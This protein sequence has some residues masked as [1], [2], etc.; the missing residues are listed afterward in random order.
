MRCRLGEMCARRCHR[1]LCT[2]NECRASIPP[3]GPKP[4][5]T[6]IERCARYGGCD[7]AKG[8]VLTEDPGE[9][10]DAGHHGDGGG[11]RVPQPVDR[12]R[13]AGVAQRL[14]RLKY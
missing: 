10:E 9:S 2:V 4:R 7:G 11:V 8:P 3:S 13:S 12:K 1:L 14:S 6:S 5:M